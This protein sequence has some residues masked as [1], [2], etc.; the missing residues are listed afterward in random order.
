MNELEK[1]AYGLCLEIEKLPAS[2][3]QTKI[4]TLAS[5]LLR[6]L[7]SPGDTYDYVNGII[8]NYSPEEARRRINGY[9]HRSIDC[10]A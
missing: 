8:Q 10:I 2:E 7:K 1:L 4:V 3:Q 5:D 9:L 6:K